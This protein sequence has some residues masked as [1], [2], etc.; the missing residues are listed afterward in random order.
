MRSRARRAKRRRR[1][2][3]GEE[4]SILALAPLMAKS[5]A[6]IDDEDDDYYHTIASPNLS[7]GAAVS[8]EKANDSDV[9]AVLV[10]VEKRKKSDPVLGVVE[11]VETRR[12]MEGDKER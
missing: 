4:G 5:W 2:D 12:E 1:S 10:V 7:W 8:Y 11:T 6:D 9:A 3:A